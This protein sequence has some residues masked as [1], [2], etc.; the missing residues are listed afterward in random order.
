MK[1]VLV[2]KPKMR[3]NQMHALVALIKTPVPMAKQKKK[4]E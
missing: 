3:V 2:F 1:N 4:V